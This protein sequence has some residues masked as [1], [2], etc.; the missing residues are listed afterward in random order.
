MLQ[1]NISNIAYMAFRLSPFIIVCFFTLE[2]FLNWNLK[3][4]VYL[5]GL[6]IACAL[7]VFASNVIPNFE[8]IIASSTTNSS[9][10]GS[11]ASTVAVLED[12]SKANSNVCVS[13][14]LG[15][16]NRN[17]SG[18][19]LST[20][21]F[22]YTLFYLLTFII[23]IPMPNGQIFKKTGQIN[24]IDKE[25]LSAALIT[26]I[27]TLVLFPLLIIVDVGWNIINGCAT[28]P[29]LG[30]SIIL[31]GLVGILWASIIAYNGNANLLYISDSLGNVC[32]RPT[33]TMF[34]CRTKNASGDSKIASLPKIHSAADIVYQTNGNLT[35]PTLKANQ[36][37]PTGQ[38]E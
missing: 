1:P 10:A 23:N 9:A 20:A 25:A 28:G 12:S 2:S 35:I 13:F 14:S 30:A 27:P 29:A 17:I 8:S 21:V 38:S 16:G 36:D 15:D 19:P 5:V 6:L 3:G 32:N 24:T 37:T 4:V 34:K 22:S 33:A 31:S 7:N 18:L 11:G 26:N